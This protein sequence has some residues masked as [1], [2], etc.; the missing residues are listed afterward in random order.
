MHI[1]PNKS[2]E[3]DECQNASKQ[4]KIRDFKKFTWKE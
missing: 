2:V 3:Q 4:W 1:R